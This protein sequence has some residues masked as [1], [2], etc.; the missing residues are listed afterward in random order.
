VQRQANANRGVLPRHG[1]PLRG[2]LLES[3]GL[4]SRKPWWPQ[5]GHRSARGDSPRHQPNP[6]R[7]CRNDCMA[8]GVDAVIM[9]RTST[10]ESRVGHGIDRLGKSGKLSVV[11]FADRC[12]HCARAG[13]SRQ[14][15]GRSDPRGKTNERS[16]MLLIMSGRTVLALKRAAL[17]LR[18]ET[19]R[20]EKG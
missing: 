2:S 16:G 4:M 19:E 9:V 7:L 8:R 6:R 15:R 1:E 13:D 5:T 17:R 12:H 14:P 11:G 18:Y 20:M 3:I 10:G